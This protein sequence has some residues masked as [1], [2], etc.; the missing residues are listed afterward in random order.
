MCVCVCVCVCVCAHL[1]SSVEK[2]HPLPDRMEGNR[3]LDRASSG[4][5]QVGGDSGWPSW[6]SGKR[7]PRPAQVFRTSSLSSSQ[8]VVSFLLN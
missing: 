4:A 2:E 6:G 7:N 1:L 5:V 8:P 3:L